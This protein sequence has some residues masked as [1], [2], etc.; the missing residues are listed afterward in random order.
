MFHLKMQ[1]GKGKTGFYAIFLTFQPSS[2]KLRQHFSHKFYGRTFI[3][4]LDVRPYNLRTY[5]H[6]TLGRTSMQPKDVRPYIL[7]SYVHIS[8]G[9]TSIHP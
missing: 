3:H 6:T 1:S 8:F 7:W 5:V 2:I 9:R 4:P